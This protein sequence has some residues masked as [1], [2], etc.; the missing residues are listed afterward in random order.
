MAKVPKSISDFG[1]KSKRF[2]FSLRPKQGW[3]PEIIFASLSGILT[4]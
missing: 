4:S 1:E 2:A 3:T